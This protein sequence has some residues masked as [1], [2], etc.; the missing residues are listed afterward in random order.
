[1]LSELD[2]TI[3]EVCPIDGVDSSGTVWFASEAT[4]EQREA[5]LAIVSQWNVT[6]WRADS[7][8]GIQRARERAIEQIKSR[9]RKDILERWPEWK[10][11]NMTARALE[12]VSIKSAG[13]VLSEAEQ[14]E[15][16]AIR[17]A[18]EWIKQRREQSD[19]EEA[20]IT[21]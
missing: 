15:E 11:A 6:D 14:Q 5:A 3:R 21:G 13:G 18:W 12:L 1:M 2:L 17:E 7:E 10:Q 20:L 8:I 19:A 4:P 16:S 9:C